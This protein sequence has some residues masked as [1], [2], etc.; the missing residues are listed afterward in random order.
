MSIPNKVLHFTCSSL[1]FVTQLSSSQSLHSSKKRNR[2]SSIFFSARWSHHEFP[3][4]LLH[5]HQLLLLHCHQLTTNCWI[6][7][8][9]AHITYH[10]SAQVTI[11]TEP[12]SF[13]TDD[14]QPLELDPTRNDANMPNIAVEKGNLDTTTSIPNSEYFDECKFNHQP[15]TLSTIRVMSTERFRRTSLTR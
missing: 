11:D 8:Y 5:C 10:Q 1:L 9:L 12:H 14:D 13:S 15:Q 4:I 6:V 2:G 7:F 3:I